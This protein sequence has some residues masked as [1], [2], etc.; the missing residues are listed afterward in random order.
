MWPRCH[1]QGLGPCTDCPGIGQGPAGGRGDGARVFLHCAAATPTSSTGPD[2]ASSSLSNTMPSQWPS[3]AGASAG[4]PSADFQNNRMAPVPH[5]VPSPALSCHLRTRTRRVLDRAPGGQAELWRL[6][7][8]RLGAS[9]PDSIAHGTGRPRA[10]VCGGH[11]QQWLQQKAARCQGPG[12]F[13]DWPDA[14]A[15]TWRRRRGGLG[16]DLAW[17]PWTRK[18]DGSH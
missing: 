14:S 7:R 9:Q 15:G 4:P 5:R 10:R 17:P 11:R 2:P 1:V 6:Q 3:N 13:G 16:P 12:L 8:P 18:C